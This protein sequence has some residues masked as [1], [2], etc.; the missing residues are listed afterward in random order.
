MAHLSETFVK[1]NVMKNGKCLNFIPTKFAFTV[2]FFYMH[3]LKHE[4][5]GVFF[6]ICL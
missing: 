3:G 4:S 5:V 6:F 1:V 2:V